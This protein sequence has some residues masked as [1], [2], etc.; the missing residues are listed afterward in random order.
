MPRGPGQLSAQ[1]QLAA[2]RDT[3]PAGR[4]PAQTL[5]GVGHHGADLR[6]GPRALRPRARREHHD[7]LSRA[8]HLRRPEG[9]AHP[10]QAR[11]VTQMDPPEYPAPT[12]TVDCIGNAYTPLIDD[13]D[14]LYGVPTLE[15]LDKK[16]IS[17]VDYAPWL[18]LP[19]GDSPNHSLCGVNA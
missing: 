14:D 4:R 10:L 9:L 5:Q 17:L 1:A 16:T 12:V 19:A 7:A 6:G 8:R 2:L 3:G 15:E 13:H 11:R 18:S